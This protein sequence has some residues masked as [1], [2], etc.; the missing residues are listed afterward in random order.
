M[1]SHFSR[2]IANDKAQSR[3]SARCTI[4]QTKTT[5]IICFASA[6]DNIEL[7]NIL[8]RQ[9]QRRRRHRTT[10]GKLH[11]CAFL[12]ANTIPLF[13]FYRGVFKAW[14][15]IV[16][17]FNRTCFSTYAHTN[18]CDIIFENIETTEWSFY[19]LSLYLALFHPPQLIVK[20]RG[21]SSNHNQSS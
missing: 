19:D 16:C 9:Q 2:A 15:R 18:R 14:A 21:S 10:A 1:N 13:F 17:I 8:A 7:P 12:R 5:G 20:P 11:K 4:T 6:W 3:A